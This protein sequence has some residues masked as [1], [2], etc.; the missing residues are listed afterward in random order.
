VFKSVR[1]VLAV[2]VLGGFFV[3]VGTLSAALVLLDVALFLV[4]PP[5]GF[6]LGLPVAAMV[7]TLLKRPRVIARLAVE[8]VSGVAV[9]PK[10][11]PG[12]WGLVHQVAESVGVEPP[13]RVTVPAAGT[14]GVARR[15]RWLGL[16]TVSREL[17]I[18]APLLA[19]LGEERLVVV[20]RQVLAPQPAVV[21][22]RDV[23]TRVLARPETR[24]WVLF[25][26]YAKVFFLLAPPLREQTDDVAKE[27]VRIDAAWRMF[28][29]R[30][31]TAAWDAGYLPVS[32]FDGFLGFWAEIEDDVESSLTLLVGP[33]L[34][35]DESV[36]LTMVGAEEAKTRV[37]WLTLAHIAGRH[38]AV[39]GTGRLLDAAGR[40]TGGPGTLAAVLDALDAGR[41]VDLGP[42]DRTPGNRDAG[43]RARRE[44]VREPVRVELDALVG[45]ALADRGLATWARTWA[46]TGVLVVRP[47]HG[48][49]MRELVVAAVAERGGTAGLRKA[50]ADLGVGLGYR[51][52][53]H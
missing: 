29:D 50:L 38:A 13:E 45:L 46:G 44:F 12:L 40:I 23:L 24:R 9:A 28:A 8:D 30:H 49:G 51:P 26:L 17:Y 34:L 42:T 20:L 22:G 10:D 18:G 19:C 11:Q 36:R 1:A 43:A 33:L 31:L 14:A 35:L 6:A 3:L 16:R 15:T 47:P 5:W 7:L 48:D 25:R 2:A 52:E 37:D 21:T 39:L 4:S 27:V 32:P 41:L 53:V